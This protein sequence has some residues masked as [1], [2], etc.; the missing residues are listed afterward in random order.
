M[1]FTVGGKRVF[2]ATGGRAFDPDLPTAALLH[3]AGMDHT[4]WAFQARALARRGRNVLALDFPGHGESQGPA[5]S[6]IDAL[7]DWILAVLKALGV[8]RMRLAGHSMGSLAA[9]EAA[10]RAGTAC[11]ALALLGFVPEMRVH[12]DLLG[13]A[14]VGAHLAAEL[15]V[16]WGFSERGLAGGNPAPGVSLPDAALRLIQRSPAA[17]LAADLAACDTYRGA[18][19]AAKTVKCPVLI[20]SGLHDRMTPAAQAEGFAAH[21]AQSRFIALRGA[22]HMLMAEQPAA[23]LDSLAAII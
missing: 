16:S 2:A 23:V 3:G 17:S 12:P 18:A 9:L 1:E 13:A 19:A 10:S 20:L 4:V 15:M 14:K 22:G 5:L 8:V 7:A 6:G 21:F 11:E